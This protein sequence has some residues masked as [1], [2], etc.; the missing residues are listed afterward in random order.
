MR[1]L[2]AIPPPSP[3]RSDIFKTTQELWT[4]LEEQVLKHPEQWIGWT[5]LQSQ[6]G[7]D[8]AQPPTTLFHALS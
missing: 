3:Q 5:R 2:E 8:P 4:A 7:I 1:F 6:L